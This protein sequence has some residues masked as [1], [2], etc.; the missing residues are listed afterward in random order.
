LSIKK[1]QKHIF[2]VMV[3]FLDGGGAMIIEMQFGLTHCHAAV[4]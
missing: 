4:V 3:A 2:L 1:T